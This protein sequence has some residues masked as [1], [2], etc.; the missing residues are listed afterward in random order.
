[1]AEEKV[2]ELVAHIPFSCEDIRDLLP[3]IVSIDR[4]GLTEARLCEV[5]GTL[6]LSGV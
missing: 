2:R 1:M 3:E 5:D 6:R 4:S